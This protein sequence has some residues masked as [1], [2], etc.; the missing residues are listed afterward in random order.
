MK[1]DFLFS[2]GE[3]IPRRMLDIRRLSKFHRVFKVKRKMKHREI[4]KLDG[5][6]LTMLLFYS[7][8]IVKQNSP[9]PTRSIIH[10]IKHVVW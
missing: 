1:T 10:L 5:S 9:R 4:Q 7:G 3:D 8:V 2:A 6:C